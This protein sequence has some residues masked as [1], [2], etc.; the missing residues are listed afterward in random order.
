MGWFSDIIEDIGDGIGDL[1][2]G[3][4]DVLSDVWDSDIGKAL[5]LGAG[6]YFGA[7]YISSWFGGSGGAAAAGLTEAEFL[8]Y[9]AAQLAGQG[10]S[11]SQIAS[12][13]GFGGADLAAAN[14][15]ATAALQG[16]DIGGISNYINQ[17]I[18][19]D[20][21]FAAADAA[22]LF[23]QGIGQ[24]QIE[25]ILNMSGN[26]PWMTNLALDAE[27]IGADALQL[28]NQTK[29]LAAV[30]QNLLY[31]GVDPF[32]AA[33]AANSV[34]MGLSGGAL[35]DK[36]LG[37]AGNL[38]GGS[39]LFGAAPAASQGTNW[40][41]TLKNAKKL[42]PGE[43]GGV[44]NQQGQ[45]NADLANLLNKLMNQQSQAQAAPVGGLAVEPFTSEKMIDLPISTLASIMGPNQMKQGQL[46]L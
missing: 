25:S 37:A 19:A 38:L 15:A 40:L 14:Y 42:M 13:L 18:L 26:S 9:D 23:D 16:L 8:A 35:T 29:N 39:G 44:P 36:L 41:D 20:A 31:A 28:W 24:K 3:I 22:Q 2:E 33:E 21:Q 11:Q 45:P 4:G 7:P 27:F 34:A 46:Q 32:L 5:V 1:V 10:L 43:T 30:E 17:N 12:T 6:A